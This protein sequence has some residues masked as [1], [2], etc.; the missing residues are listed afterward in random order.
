[1]LEELM[2]DSLKGGKLP[3]IPNTRPRAEL[4]SEAIKE[5][6]RANSLVLNRRFFR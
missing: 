5:R 3:A 6:Q 1:L 4:L 2:Y